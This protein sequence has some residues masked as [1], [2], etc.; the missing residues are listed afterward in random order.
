MKDFSMFDPVKNRRMDEIDRKI[1]EVFGGPEMFEPEFNLRRQPAKSN[2]GKQGMG[3]DQLRS[4]NISPPVK[5]SVT[6]DSL[7]D[8]SKI[9][10]VFLIFFRKAD[11]STTKETHGS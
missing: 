5:Q 7:S 4:R 6:H 10:E 11:Q 3:A 1:S 2:L 8:A 9:F